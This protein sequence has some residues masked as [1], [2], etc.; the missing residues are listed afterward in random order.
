MNYTQVEIKV[1]PIALAIVL[2]IGLLV[3]FLL[4]KQSSKVKNIPLI[5]IAVTMLIMEVVKQYRSF[6][7]GSYSLWSIPLHFCSLFMLW[8]SIA[9]FSKGRV[10]EVGMSIAFASACLFFVVFYYDP[11]TIIGGASGDFFGSFSSFHTFFYHHFIILFAV[12][13]LTL[14]LHKPKWADI[15]WI[16]LA[17]TIFIAVAVPI[18]NILDTNYASLLYNNLTFMENLKVN[19]GYWVYVL[20]MYL[21]G[22]VGTTLF[23]SIITSVHNKITKPKSKKAITLTQ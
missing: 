5:V 14:K 22:V 3:G 15:K 11:R 6:E 19:Y 23:H 18:A 12:L 2:I 1:L 20:A 8:F 4:R 17:Y 7:S 16:I 9:A 21:T 13:Q 10:K